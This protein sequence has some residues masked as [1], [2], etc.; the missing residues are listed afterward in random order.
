VERIED[1]LE[2]KK[3]KRIVGKFGVPFLD[4]FLGG[5]MPEDLI[6]ISAP[7]G[8]GKTEMAVQIAY[9]NAHKKVLLIA[10]EADREEIENRSF[11]R[12]ISKLYWSDSEHRRPRGFMSYRDYLQNTINLSQYEPEA[13]KIYK[14]RPVPEV[15]Y[16][17]AEFTMNH[18]TQ[19]VMGTNYDLIILDHLDYFDMEQDVSENE[20]MSN[21]MKLLR[22]INDTKKTPIVAISHVRKTQG[23][24]KMPSLDD[25]HG[26]SNK[27]KQAKT[28]IMLSPDKENY[29]DGRRFATYIQV[30][31]SRYG[32]SGSI[33]A[34]QLFDVGLNSYEDTYTLKQMNFDQTITDLVTMPNWYKWRNNEKTNN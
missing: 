32:T 33:V 3:K 1:I 13:I 8:C 2:R 26:S 20:S 22:G 11:F 10:L 23:K 30:L 27:A 18:L 25:L 9:H 19:A 6:I 31:K 15:L 21:L 28:V 7:T 17:D 16:R 34:H 5:I 14:S 12:I 24:V 4:D 29:I